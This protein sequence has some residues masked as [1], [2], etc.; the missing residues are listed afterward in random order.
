MGVISQTLSSSLGKKTLMAASG[1]F[2]GLFVLIHLVGNSTALLGRTAFLSYTVRLHS[3][4]LLLPV[5]EI[6]LLTVFCAHVFLAIILSYENRQARPDRYAVVKSRG[7]QTL[8]SRSMLYS[9]LLILIFLVTHLFNFHFISSGTPI[10][11]L[12]RETLNKPVVA[13]FY[14]TGVLTLGFH[15]SHGLW[16]LFQ[17]LGLEHPKYTRTLDKKA[18]RFGLAVGLLFALIP[19][20][21]LFL[22]GFLL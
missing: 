10:A 4:G 15:L 3:L 19:L 1:A 16:S 17:T 22:P 11:D 2:L 5:L 7:G 6:L 14:I 13:I 20:L 21:A 18:A 8:A 12:V 9:G